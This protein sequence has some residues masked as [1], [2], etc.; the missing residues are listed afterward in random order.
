MRDIFLLIVFMIILFQTLRAAQA[1]VLGWTWLTLMTPQKLVWGFAGLVPFNLILAVVT[2]GAVPLS[3]DRRL[4]RWNALTLLWVLFILDI[5]ITSLFSLAPEITWDRWDRTIKTM[6][7]GLLIP[8]AMTDRNRIHA[9]ILVAAVSLSYF[10]IK[11]GGFTLLTGG[12]SHVLGPPASELADNNNLAVAL[13]MTLPLL[14]YLRLQSLAR[15]ARIASTI[16]MVL[17]SIAVLGTYSRGGLVGLGI[18]GAYLL[19]TSKQ[20]I[21]LAILSVLALTA[22]FHFMPQA[23]LARMDTIETAEQDASFQDRLDAWRVALNIAAQHPLTGSGFGASERSDIYTRFSP[24]NS[25]YVERNT[26]IGAH[27]YHSIYFQV[28]GDHGYPGLVLFLGLLALTWRCL[29][30]VRR[31]TRRIPEQAWAFDLAA[32]LQVSLITYAV[33]GAALSMAYY[34]LPYIFM[35]IAIALRETVETA[36]TGKKPPAGSRPAPAFSTAQTGPAVWAAV[37]EVRLS[38]L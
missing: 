32:M 15:P 25:I 28:L 17:V 30:R 10:G 22:A 21:P 31:A 24:E 34:D 8:I 6:A 37:P 9:L 14:N 20:R 19:W 29:G 13:C 26:R 7:L 16:A 5:T 23:W 36:A 11:G 18:M 1:G 2:L 12:A 27:A 4:P 35:G 38:E 3:R 33:A